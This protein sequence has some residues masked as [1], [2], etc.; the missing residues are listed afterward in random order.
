MATDVKKIQIFKRGRHVASDGTALEFT[1]ADLIACAKAYDPA[2]HEAPI[3]I[4][5]PK[6]DLPAYGWVK[7]LAYADGLDAEPH[8][9]DTQ[10]SEWVGAGKFKKVSASLY[11]PDAPNNPVPGVYYL[12]HVGFL[13]AQPPAIKGLKQASFADDEAGVVEFGDWGDR[14]NAS[15]WR[16]LR[17]WIIGEKGLETA[18]AVVPDYQVASLEE[19]ARADGKSSLGA[20]PA[21]AFN[22]S[23]SLENSMSEAQRAEIAEREKKLKADQEALAAQQA[24]FAERETKVKAAE[25]AAQRKAVAEFVGELVKAGKVLPKD[26]A[27]LVAYMAGPNESGV[28]E[29]GEGDAKVSKPS[30]EW[31]REFLTGLPKQVDY[32]ERS[33][34]QTQAAQSVSFAA[35]PGYSVDTQRLELHSKALAYQKQHPGTAYEA[36]VAAVS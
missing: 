27:G 34:A 16:R 3:V 13:G 21:M 18:D 20:L 23:Q 15:L 22:E 6:H 1:E 17:D 10:F 24:E 25:A 31:L 26:E 32:S 28:I 12:R 7:S 35:P 29:F 2:K 14:T 8:Q 30:G 11:L 9:V 33:A 36:A 4:G 5:H 19:A